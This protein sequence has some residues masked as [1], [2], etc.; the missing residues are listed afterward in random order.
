MRHGGLNP[1]TDLG[2]GAWGVTAQRPETANSKPWN[3]QTRLPLR[4][5]AAGDRPEMRPEVW[6]ERIRYAYRTGA[7]PPS[8]D[9]L[10]QPF[11]L[12]ELLGAELRARRD[13]V[14]AVR[15]GV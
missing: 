12:Y 5:E 9:L 4:N 7:V 1:A 11:L 2:G 8:D 13:E 3:G 10:P 14:P 6:A 15:K